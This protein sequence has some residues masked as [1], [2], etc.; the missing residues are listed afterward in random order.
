[1][2]S[3]WPAK[4]LTRVE[5]AYILGIAASVLGQALPQQANIL[6]AVA[7]QPNP[8]GSIPLDLKD[9]WGAPPRQAVGRHWRHG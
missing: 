6:I 9:Q 4:R 7:D 1:V 3:Q 5:H 8:A 2:K